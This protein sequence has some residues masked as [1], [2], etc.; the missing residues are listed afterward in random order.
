MHKLF[1]MSH[2][3]RTESIAGMN[4]R[5]LFWRTAPVNY[6]GRTATE[7]LELP[8]TFITAGDQLILML[9]W[10]S[11]ARDTSLKDSLAFGAGSHICGGQALAL[12]IADAWLAALKCRRR[13]IDWG[14]HV[15]EPVIPAVFRQY[16]G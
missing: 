9:P 2:E 16:R 3:D 6:I 7:D 14:S 13:D 11:H 5:E 10:A 15:K 8:G 12:S 1:E 4:S